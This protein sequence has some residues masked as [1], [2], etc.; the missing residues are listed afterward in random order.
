MNQGLPL[1]AF[2]G[3][4][5]WPT[6][7]AKRVGYPDSR[8]LRHQIG[9]YWGVSPGALRDAR[10]LERDIASVVECRRRQ[11]ELGHPGADYLEG[12]HQRRR[13][14]IAGLTI[15]TH[16]LLEGEPLLPAPE[17][18]ARQA[19]DLARVRIDELR[20]AALRA[21]EVAR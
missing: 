12:L 21:S 7:V 3:E 6:P 19:K 13:Q 15:E 20:S 14:I 8:A 18:A 1:F 4:R 2:A 11:G 5:P 9:G 17:R 16:R 10:I